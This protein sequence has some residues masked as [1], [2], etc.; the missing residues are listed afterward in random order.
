MI[1]MYIWYTVYLLSE[2]STWFSNCKTYRFTIHVDTYVMCGMPANLAHW[3]KYASDRASLS[4]SGSRILVAS[5]RR[6][7]IVSRSR[8]APQHHHACRYMCVCIC[9]MY[10]QGTC[11]YSEYKS[12]NTYWTCSASIRARVS[13]VFSG[14]VKNTSTHTYIVQLYIH[15]G[16]WLYTSCT[17]A[18]VYTHCKRFAA[19]FGTARCNGYLLWRRTFFHISIL[20]VSIIHMYIVQIWHSWCHSNKYN[21]LRFNTKLGQLHASSGK[22]L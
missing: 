3:P 22:R 10:V 21:V 15:I 4:I 8:S 6:R 16:T 9:C 13:A 18:A 2:I 20:H 17:T 11:T 12:D 5:T 14:S 1:Y 19:L 7:L